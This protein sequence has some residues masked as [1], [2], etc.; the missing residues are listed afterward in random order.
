VG[1]AR[2]DELGGKWRNGVVERIEVKSGC[3]IAAGKEFVFLREEYRS[4]FLTLF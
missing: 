2:N 3:Q 4:N 1:A